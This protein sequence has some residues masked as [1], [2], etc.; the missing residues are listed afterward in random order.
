MADGVLFNGRYVV[1]PGA[2][3]YI[4]ANSMEVVTSGST[5]IPIVLGQA[6]CGEPNK[7]M[8]F[9]SYSSAR[10]V[11]EGGELL[12]AVQLMFSPSPA[13]GGGASTVGVVV[14][15]PNT[16]A[17]ASA[18]NIAF[19]SKAYGQNSNKISVKVSNGTISGSKKVTVGRYD[20][21]VTEVFDNAGALIKIQYTGEDAVA[22]VTVTV[23]SGSATTLEV[24]TGASDASATT[25]L[26]V[27]LSDGRYDTLGELVE[28]IGS[29]AGYS[30]SLVNP[31]DASVSSSKLDAV[32]NADVKTSNYLLGVNAGVQSALNQST[33]VTAIVGGSVTNFSETYLTG[34]ATGAVPA[35]WVTALDKVKKEFSDILVI[36]SSSSSIHAEALSH[37][38][39][40]ELRNQR[41][42]LFT[43]GALGETV[44]QVKSRALGLNSSRAVL[45]YPGM[46]HGSADTLLAPYFT[47]AMIAG[48]VAG[49]SPSEPITFDYFS[50]LGLEG[51]L[52]EGDPDIEK[53]V[54]AGVCVIEKVNGRGFRLVQGVTTYHGTNNILYKEI[55]VRRAADNISS[56]I[57]KNLE[58]IFVGKKGTPATIA[59][60]SA[61]TRSML[62][63]LKVN[64][65]INS[66]S[67]ISVSFIGT[68]VSVSYQVAPINPINY[69][70]ITS[71]FVPESIVS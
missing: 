14:V 9:N 50:I 16:T 6:T 48:R 1:H 34:G 5:N 12:K 46:Y 33:L 41:Q 68:I 28:Y 19:T 17:S 7:V 26:L 69:I 36:L 20:T 15:N 10:A 57:R 8:Y 64:G 56:T 13:G 38:Q 63:M 3:D 30:A 53:L 52:V 54:S 65:E 40:M 70:L 18:G 35:S 71:H 27:T 62:E 4:D 61:Q 31:Y 49:V 37:I 2:Y 43:G 55:S 59:D 42:L 39:Q 58:D 29:I 60:V 23:T 67:N 32:S 21:P 45:A 47:A 11:L 22:K 24:K 51:N 66:Y 25:N 44:E